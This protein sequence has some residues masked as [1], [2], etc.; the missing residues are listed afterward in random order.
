MNPLLIHRQSRA[1]ATTGLAVLSTTEK[2]VEGQ[3][4]RIDST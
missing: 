4:E 1:A 3:G 2:Q